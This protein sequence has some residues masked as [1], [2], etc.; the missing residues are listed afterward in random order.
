[1]YCVYGHFHITMVSVSYRTVVGVCIRVACWKRRT[2][3][4]TCC[5]Q[6]RNGKHA[7]MNVDYERPS[8]VTLMTKYP[9]I[10][11]IGDMMGYIRRLER[12]GVLRHGMVKVCDIFVQRCVVSVSVVDVRIVCAMC[13]CRWF[14]QRDGRQGRSCRWTTGGVPSRTRSSTPPSFND[15]NGLTRKCTKYC[16]WGGNV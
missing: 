4:S 15:F 1:M 6:S 7:S 12:T 3:R 14:H 9:H 10:D 13:M 8:V 2:G 16:R 11:E 5:G